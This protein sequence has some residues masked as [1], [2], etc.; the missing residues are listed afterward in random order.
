MRSLPAAPAKRARPVLLALLVLLPA[1]GACAL[2]GDLHAEAKPADVRIAPTRT[3]ADAPAREARDSADPRPMDD[4]PLSIDVQDAILLALENNRELS[5]QRLRP[6]IRETF[7]DEERAVFDPVLSAAAAWSRRETDGAGG[8]NRSDVTGTVEL[9]LGVD[10]VFPTGTAVGVSATADRTAASGAADRAAAR[11]GVTVAQPVL[12]GQGSDVNL[13]SLRQA[14]LDTRITEYELRGYA[15]ALVAQVEETYWDCALASEQIAI[16]EDS[17]RLAEQQL[18]E[19]E[20]RIAVGTLGEVE[21]APAQAEV[22]QRRE[23]LIAARASLATTRLRLLRLLNVPGDDPYARELQMR[24]EPPMERVELDE[25]AAHVQVALR[26]RPELNQS[27][28]AVRRDELEVVRTRN[29][30]LPRLDLFLTLG[31]S[32]YARSFGGAAGDLDGHGYDVTVGAAFERPFFNRAAEAR[33]RRATLNRRQAEAA[34]ANLEQLVELDVRSAYIAVERASEE[35]AATA[36]TRAFREEALRAETEKFRVGASTTFL[37]AQAQRDLLASRIAELQAAV[38]Y[39]KAL[40]DLYRLEG[41]LLTRRGIA[42]P[43]DGPPDGPAA[44]LRGGAAAP[45]NG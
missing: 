40:V 33:H 15:E 3:P 1:A 28:L 17:L 19:T 4:G 39:R 35:V 2:Q 22:A 16:F 43:G 37:V 45:P 8:A 6:S 25:V 44:L 29:G 9:G 26:M 27:R 34:L 7:E 42:A 32:G 11:V 10:Q 12:R 36:V 14:R 38:S 24:A 5:V 18:T 41:S 13:A 20:E 31:K 30:L 21:R 23:G